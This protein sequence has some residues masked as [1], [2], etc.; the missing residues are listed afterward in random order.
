MW[1]VGAWHMKLRTKR[2]SVMMLVEELSGHKTYLLPQDDP[3][4]NHSQ[5]CSP[6][7]PLPPSCSFPIPLA[8][9]PAAVGASAAHSLKLPEN[10]EEQDQWPPPR[11]P[12][13][14]QPHQDGL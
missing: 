14:C 10:A 1:P 9:C 8:A 11:L 5:V 3:F 13:V 12:A 4:V 7:F 2:G 6:P